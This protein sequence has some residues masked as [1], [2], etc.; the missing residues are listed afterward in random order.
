[1]AEIR[2][3]S[4]R[5]RI[6]SVMHPIG[7]GVARERR[8]RTANASISNHFPHMGNGDAQQDVGIAQI[9]KIGLDLSHALLLTS[10]AGFVANLSA[11][12]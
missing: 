4:A 11:I 6:G 1:M 9:V 8:S 10:A 5:G 7:V 3:A 12:L 2:V